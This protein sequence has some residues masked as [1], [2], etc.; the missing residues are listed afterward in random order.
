MSGPVISI[1][2]RTWPRLSILGADPRQGKAVDGEH[3]YNVALAPKAVE[4]CAP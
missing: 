3:A 4:G 2:Y 1:S